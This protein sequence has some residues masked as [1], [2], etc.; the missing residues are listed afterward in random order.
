MAASDGIV[1]E[2]LQAGSDALMQ[3]MRICN[4]AW[5]SETSALQEWLKAV[6]M[7]ILKKGHSLNCNNHRTLSLLNTV[8]KVLLC[9]EQQAG[10]RKDRGTVQQILALRFIVEK[11]WRKNRVAYN[12]FGDKTTGY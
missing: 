10:F 11:M 2:L 12:C 1:G 3:E 5:V 8:S 7:P 9:C 6:V 4:I